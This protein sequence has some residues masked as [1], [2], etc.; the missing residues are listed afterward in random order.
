VSTLETDEWTELRGF[1]LVGLSSDETDAKR[2]KNE[3]REI[4]NKFM[5]VL[6][7]FEQQLQAD[8]LKY[9]PNDSWIQ[10]QHV[11]K[12][13]LGTVQ[14]D[15]RDWEDGDEEVSDSDDEGKD[16]EGLSPKE[17]EDD[18]PTKRPKRPKQSKHQKKPKKSIPGKKLRPALDVINRIRWDSSLEA[19]KFVVGYEDRFLGVREMEVKKWKME[20]TDLEFIPL[21]RV[22]Y[23]KRLSDGV[24]VWDRETKTDLVFGAGGQE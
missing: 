5:E 13:A 6:R 14:V 17:S 10:V 18:S 15:D 21:H 7:N 16:E 19:G 9:D 1:Y 24:L 22:V 4:E 23:F 3:K 12:S 20:Q 2:P 11:G 8:A